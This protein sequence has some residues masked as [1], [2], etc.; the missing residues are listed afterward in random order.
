MKALFNKGEVGEGV[1]IFV[2]EWSREVP[3][4]GQHTVAVARTQPPL[5]FVNKVLL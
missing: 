4:L 3:E 5:T 2:E 1:K